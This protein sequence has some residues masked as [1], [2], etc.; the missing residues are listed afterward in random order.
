MNTCARSLRSVLIVVVA[1]L[2]SVDWPA[3]VS[4]RSLGWTVSYAQ[5]PNE[6]RG[7]SVCTR[8][9]YWTGSGWSVI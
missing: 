5:W 7:G 1:T 9:P 3:L 8:Q 6:G 4:I 2:E